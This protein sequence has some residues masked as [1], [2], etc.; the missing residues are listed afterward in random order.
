[1]AD[2]E[3][4]EMGEL[5]LSQAPEKLIPTLDPARRVQAMGQIAADDVHIF[6]REETLREMV[7]YSKT[8]TSQE[9]GGA[10]IGDFYRWKDVHWV[11]IAGYVKAA[12]YVN[13]SASFKFTVE[14]WAQI[15][16]E[17]EKRFNDRQV[18]GWHHTHP[19][20]G[21]FLS[22]MDMFIHNNFFNLPWQVALVVDPVADT[23]VF[24]QWKRKKVV[25]CGF[26][27]IHDR[28]LDAKRS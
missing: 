5:E 27:Y 4:G 12:H 13:T 3:F 18:V 9:L 8:S 28:V 16:R 22:H 25:G 21:I 20:Y 15:T 2:I 19:R 26:F 11:E 1:M 23:M 6:L 17:K 24:F 7:I 14:S 10:M